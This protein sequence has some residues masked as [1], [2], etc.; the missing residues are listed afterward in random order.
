[1]GDVD[2]AEECVL[3]L[4]TAY[5]LP[6]GVF[7]VLVR[8]GDQSRAV[9]EVACGFECVGESVGL[10][11]VDVERVTVREVLLNE[12][13]AL[14]K[15]D[16]DA[17]D[18]GF[19]NFFPEVVDQC[20]VA[21]GQQFFG[22][23][24][25]QGAQAGAESGAGDDAGCDHGLRKDLWMRLIVLGCGEGFSAGGRLHTSFLVEWDGFRLLLDCGPSVLVGLRRFGIDPMSVDAVVISH[26]HGDHFGGLPFLDRF[27]HAFERPRPLVVWG[28]PLLRERFDMALGALFAG[29]TARGYELQMHSYAR[30]FEV[31]GMACLALPV[32]HDERSNPHGLR[33]GPLAF[34]GDSRWTPALEQ[35][36]EGASVFICECG[37]AVPGRPK[38]CSLSELREHRARL[39]CERLFL[40]H[41][42]QDVLD[43]LPLPDFEVLED[44]Q[45]IRI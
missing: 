44:G 9:N 41:L 30:E 12:L 5:K 28:P 11:L 3:V 16:D 34:S 1:M 24:S 42:G 37:V 27:F 35:L 36:A 18:A 17:A 31:G 33:L 43:L 6:A 22:N 13:F 2:L 7:Q 38:H 4:V 20:F 45:E 39:R 14:S 26:L 21:I 25:C 19:P 23:H 29:S 40:T 32:D 8:K 10:L 15:H